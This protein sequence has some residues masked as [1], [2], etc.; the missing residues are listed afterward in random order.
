MARAPLPLVTALMLT[1]LI[2]PA[3]AQGVASCLFEGWSAATDPMGGPVRARP[4]PAAPVVG[5]LPPP[6][7]SGV[8]RVAVAVTV[9]AYR[10]GWFRIGEASFSEEAGSAAG[11]VDV[12]G[13]VTA[14]A[15][16]AQ[17][18]GR[19]LRA[20]PQV[21]AP[22][23]GPLTGFRREGRLTVL[24]G[25]EGVEGRRLLACRGMWVEAATELGRGW[26]ERV[27]ARQLGPCE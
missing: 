11:L 17:L 12:A 2:G 22:L 26:V 4:D 25:P 1:A 21:S 6:A 24:Q 27:C 14:E 5:R 18:A 16:T 13:W 19:D 10:D 20:A 9:T 8:D 15:V 23:V 7:D 3:A